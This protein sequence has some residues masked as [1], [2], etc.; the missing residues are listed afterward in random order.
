[1]GGWLYSERTHFNVKPY[2]F[3]CILIQV[4]CSHHKVPTK[5][6]GCTLNDLGVGCTKD[7]RVSMEVSNWLVSWFISPT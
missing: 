4:G 7:T 6:D 3:S 5:E 1:M 2:P